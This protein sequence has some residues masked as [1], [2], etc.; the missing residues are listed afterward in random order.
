MRREQ[1]EEEVDHLTK[2][3]KRAQGTTSASMEESNDVEMGE[4]NKGINHQQREEDDGRRKA[5]IG[6]NTLAMLAAKT[7]K[8]RRKR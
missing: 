3:T 8:N 6:K 5:K 2:S 1:T 4:S 7:V